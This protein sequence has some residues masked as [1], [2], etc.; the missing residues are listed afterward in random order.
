MR[1]F[2]NRASAKYYQY[3]LRKLAPFLASAADFVAQSVQE[4]W[5]R[6]RMLID[7]AEWKVRVGVVWSYGMYLRM[8][9]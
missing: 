9:Q 2:L 7:R 3:T 8:A 6:Y 5:Q 1:T 4:S